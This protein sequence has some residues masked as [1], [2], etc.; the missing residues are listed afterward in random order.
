MNTACYIH[1][2]V[3]IRKGTSVTLYKLWRERKPTV[4]HFH[5]F[6]SKCYI[7]ADREQRRKLDPKSDEGIF[8][9]FSTKSRAYRVFN[10]KTKTMIESINVVINECSDEKV[11]DV[12]PDVVTSSP[13]PEDSESQE[14]S[15][16]TD[17]ELNEGQT[18]KGPS[19]RV[20]KNR[21]NELIIGNLESCVM[22]ISRE[23]I[24]IACFVSK[25]EPKNVKETLTDEFWI[26]AMQEELN[27]F[28]RN[29]VWDLVPRPEG[30]NIIGTKWVYRNKSNESVVVK[31][32]QAILVAQGCS[33]I[34]GVDL[35]I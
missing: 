19:I 18:S 32:N 8:P 35:Y 4:K 29:E 9:G 5:V 22:T 15:G 30:V 1:N 12:E 23:V 10:N 24:S 11:H 34:E 3:T 2:R 21:P 25:I 7:L 17:T 26:E 20:Q 13:Q 31:R 6:G 33:Q 28:K 16:K 14:N 27:Q